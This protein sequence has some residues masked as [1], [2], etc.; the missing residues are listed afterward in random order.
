MNRIFA[1]LVAVFGLLA[2]WACQPAA[3]N[4]AS[5]VEVGAGASSESDSQTAGG[6]VEDSPQATE[7]V[8][9]PDAELAD[10]PLFRGDPQATGVARSGLP[11]ALEL[12]WQFHVERGAFEGTPA[13]VDQQVILADLDGKIYALDL[14][15][16]EE[17]WVHDTGTGFTASPAVRDGRVF[18]GDYLGQFYCLDLR[19]G[20]RLWEFKV[21]ADIDASA[22]FYGDWVLFGSQ[23]ARLYCLDAARGELVWQHEL[24]D[25]IRCMPTVV[26]GRCFVAGCDGQ[27]HILRL[28]DGQPQAT[29]PIESP[30]MV[31]P[32]VRGSH[33]YFGTEAGSFFCIDWR[34]AEV[35][36]VFQSER[37][38]SIR[39]S[40]AVSEDVVI[41]GSRDRRVVALDP[42]TGAERWQFAARQRIDA[43]PV[44]AGQRVYVA[45]ADGR[46]YA[47]DRDSGELLWE[48]ETGGG[49]S[50]S[51]AVG[52]ERLVIA[53]TDG[54]VYCFGPGQ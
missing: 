25:Q 10:W 18:L 34:Q 44:I 21:E 37:G 9:S 12:Q 42:Q 49:F 1:V 22:N 31:T 32:A 47:L 23:D 39:S 43:S 7:A 20:Q 13:I 50:G 11:D 2:A 35:V 33:V 53:N 30:T 48:F 40:P 4:D 52:F 46:L 26:E 3:T 54:V 29:V 38:Q 19:D 27:L 45:A 17:K 15:T 28:D 6:D 14:A 5:L 8:S 36:W 16:G 51:P 24:Q 41:F